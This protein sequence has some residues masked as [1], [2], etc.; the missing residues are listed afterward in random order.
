[1]KKRFPRLSTS[2]HLNSL[3]PVR[4]PNHFM[5]LTAEIHSKTRHKSPLVRK[6]FKPS[7]FHEAK[8]TISRKFSA[9]EG[10][11][12]FDEHD[13]SLQEYKNSQKKRLSGEFKL[14]YKCSYLDNN[15]AFM[16][17]FNTFE[18]FQSKFCRSIN[19]A[20]KSDQLN[21]K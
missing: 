11:P 15:K 8:T 9:F 19:E 5:N 4:N 21:N 2:Y 20:N 12:Y 14:A 13:V 7:N 16:N 10:N 3:S 6:V 18:T 1:M 17:S